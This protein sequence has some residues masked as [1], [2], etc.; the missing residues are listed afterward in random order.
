MVTTITYICIICGAAT[1]A[2]AAMKLVEVL[3]R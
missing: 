3:D 1:M 2:W